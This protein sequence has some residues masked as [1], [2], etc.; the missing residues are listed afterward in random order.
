MLDEFYQWFVGFSDAESN[1]SIVPQYET[2]GNKINRFNFRFTIGL[3]KDDKDVLLNI[4]NLLNIGNVV[5]YNNEC[6]FIVT[7]KKL[8][9]NW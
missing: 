3:H 8:K 2:G 4:H 6:K 9:G 7:D 5:E 1:F